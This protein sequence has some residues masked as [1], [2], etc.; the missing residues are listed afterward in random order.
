MPVTNRWGNPEKTIICQC[1]EGAWEI[2][3]LINSFAE[4]SA[5]LD[6]V[7]YPVDVIADLSAGKA[8]TGF[9]ARFP[10]IRDASFS[11]HPNTKRFFLVANSRFLEMMAK[12]FAHFNKLISGRLFVVGTLDEA[13]EMIAD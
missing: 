7:S 12:L 4:V 11:E 6:T 8:P 1:F 2:D 9:L 5:M 3:E 13:Y 10:D